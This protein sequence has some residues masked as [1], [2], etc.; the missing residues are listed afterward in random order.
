MHLAP[1]SRSFEMWKTPPIPMSIDIYLFNWT[2]PTPFDETF[3][4]PILVELG[5]YRFTEVMDKVDVV[6]SP[7]NSTVS[8]RRK[9]TYFFD[10]AGSRGQLGDTVTTLNIIA[11]SAAAKA[12]SWSYVNKKAVSVGLKIYNQ[13]GHVTKT[14]GELLFDGYQDDMIDMAREMP[15]FL[16]D[17]SVQVPFDRFGW[18]YMVCYMVLYMNMSKGG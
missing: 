4:K 10:A 1:N 8:Y 12:M 15:S 17:E 6:W 7:H 11:L 18:F 14:A 16:G 2:N 5:P 9:S 13:L 3:E